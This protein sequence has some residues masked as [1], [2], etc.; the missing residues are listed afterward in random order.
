MPTYSYACTACDNAFDAVQSIHDSA[1]TEC[2]ECTAPVRKLFGSVGTLDIA[3]AIVAQ[4]AECE[5][6][7]V[8]LPDGPLREIGEF[9]VE[10]HLHPDVNATVKVKVVPEDGVSAA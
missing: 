7:E 3:D 10:I 5:K 1:L 4:G 6:R 8:R 9:D 2:P